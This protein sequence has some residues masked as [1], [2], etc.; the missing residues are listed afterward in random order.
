MSVSDLYQKAPSN[1]VSDNQI[2]LDEAV[3]EDDIL[4][5][6][7]EYREVI[8]KK[9]KAILAALMYKAEPMLKNDTEVHFLLHSRAEEL[10]LENERA[11]L[12]GFLRR[13]LR[14]DQIQ[15]FHFITEAE[16][17]ARPSTNIQRLDYIAERYPQIAEF[18]KNMQQEPPRKK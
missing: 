1:S 11:E 16:A 10:E 9:G 5:C 17:E 14:N 3:T 6:W 2:L 15:L 7:M 4:R 8:L 13:N 18:I 12:L